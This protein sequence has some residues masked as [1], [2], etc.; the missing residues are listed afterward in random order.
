MMNHARRRRASRFELSIE[1]RLDVITE[2][3]NRRP[4]MPRPPRKVAGVAARH[5]SMEASVRAIPRAN[6]P[7]QTERKNLRAL[8]LGGGGFI[9]SHL[10]AALLAQGAQ[11]RVLER[12]YRERTAALPEHP[13]LQWQE[14][15]FGN[16]QDIHRA[17][18]DVDNVFT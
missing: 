11:V 8:V 15:D 2:R 3:N 10:V 17:L 7:V 12:P 16:T 5:G 4:R 14:G 1:T 13:A 6:S 18:E 9:G